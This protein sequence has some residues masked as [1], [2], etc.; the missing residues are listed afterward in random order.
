[1]EFSKGHGLASC[2]RT[3]FVAWRETRETLAGHDV[4]TLGFGLLCTLD[5][6]CTMLGVSLCCSR[7]LQRDRDREGRKAHVMAT[8]RMHRLFKDGRPTQSCVGR[9]RYRQ[10]L[11]GVGALQATTVPVLAVN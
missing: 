1:M 10:R 3:R 8:Q 11:H 2:T 7:T 9:W 6:L 5:L 4:K